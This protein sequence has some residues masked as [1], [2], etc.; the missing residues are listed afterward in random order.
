MIQEWLLRQLN[1][2]D[3]FVQH[4]DEVRLAFGHP[5]LLGVGLVL[6]VPISVWIY[7]RQKWNLPSVPPL[8]RFT[9]TAT[10]VLI[11]LLL[12]L[13]LGGPY[14]AL[15]HQ[16]EQKPIVALL[17]D[18][19]QSMQLP[20]GPFESDGELGPLAAAAGY[21]ASGSL[22]DS[23]TRRAINRMSRAKLA[24]TVV[25]NSQ[26]LLER[27][28]KS[29]E[30]RYYSFSRRLT[31]LG[32]DPTQPQLPEPPNPGGPTT[33]IGDAIA[34]VLDEAG[35]RPVAGILLF[36]DGQNTGGRSPIE[37]A[38]A[39]GG[40]GVPV[41]AVPVGSTQKAR[42]V[43]IV[44]L[45]T[46]ALVSRGDT[47]KVAV[48]LESNGLDHR[49]VKVELKDG[50]QLLD[51]KEVILDGS[52]QQQ[53][54]LTFLA[55][56]PGARYLTVHVP[57]QPEEAD[58]LHGNNT[59]TAFVRVSDEKIKVQLLEGLPRWD[60]RFLKNA[61]HRDH[62]VGGRSGESIDLCLEAE[63]RR[64]Q[65]AQRTKLLPR[66]VDAL[67]EYHTIILGDASPRM[68]DDAF[69]QALDHAVREKGVGLIVAAGPLSMPHRYG[70]A[71][72]ELLPVRL[73]RGQAGRYPR[74]VPSFR[75]ELTPEGTLHDALRFYDEPG[76]NQNAWSNLAPYFW[77][78]AA[79]RPA[80]GATVLAWNPIPGPYGKL[81]LIAQH[82]AGKGKVMFVGTDSTWLWRRNV[83]DRFFYKF[84]G[85]SIR[86]VA[87]RDPRSG[88]KCW[89]EI[90]PLRAQPGEQAEVELM[91]FT[92]DGSPRVDSTLS[93]QVQGGS[94]AASIELAADPS[95]KGR[96]RG[97]FTPEATGEYQL[98][99]RP[100]DQADSAEARLH[101]S[102]APEELRHPYVNRAALEQWATA[103]GGQKIELASLASVEER[104]QGKSVPTSFHR[105]ATVW[106]N[107][108]TL[109]LLIF[110]YSL[111][112]GIRRLVG[113][114]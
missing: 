56:D 28:A 102:V 9:L 113:L 13:V 83:G 60:F 63:W 51:S 86:A 85:Q 99:Y 58:E 66:T 77:C 35:G 105:E 26:P 18:H 6:L 34:H 3:E 47:A 93:V 111:D 100:D 2:T 50:E 68:I 76:H 91:A 52:E 5:V 33:Q 53:V 36:S 12:V 45:F 37:A 78:A 1:I 48:T 19:S 69:V 27:L 108:L 29:F 90:R 81:P 92:A 87:R 55:K 46:S 24:Q 25:Q 65:P 23:E 95:V 73:H 75:I 72:H 7:L 40:D 71:L 107:G 21:R 32:V 98:V 54:E 57:P 89:I 88:K 42:D 104:L 4:V 82:Y 8:L 15:D 103:S 114:S 112:V 14:L 109:A 84:W 44:D 59:D 41:F 10:R 31:P 110:L 49:P 97:K 17:F 16:A 43:A 70:D 62:G 64:Q 74:G 67:S 79:E 38:R 101:V 22:A 80:P 61:L 94:G 96:Y 39:A 30:L 20:A 106:D 11:L